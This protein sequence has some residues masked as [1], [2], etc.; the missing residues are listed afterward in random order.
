MATLTHSGELVASASVGL[1]L[2]VARRE[3]VAE[4]VIRLTLV[5]LTGG[6]LPAWMPGAHI[7]LTGPT[8]I[9]GQYSLCGDPD[10]VGVWHVAVLR[11]ATG[12]GG[13]VAIHDRL[14]KGDSILAAGPRNHFRLTDSP[15]Y[16]FIAGGI[17]ITPIIPMITLVERENRPWRLIYT[18]RATATMAFVNELERYGARVELHPSQERG[19]PDLEALI[20]AADVS[21]A[22]FCCGPPAMVDAVSALC[23]SDPGRELRVERFIP[24]IDAEAAARGAAFDVEFIRSERVLHVA[25]GQTIVEAMEL[26]GLEA[27]CSCR[28]GVCG[29]CETRVIA[30]TPDHRDSVLEAPERA[31][32]N[33][34]MICVSRSL[35]PTL[36]LDA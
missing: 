26:A 34:M 36:V 21:A 7:D 2:T 4:D 25:N 1:R 8:G 29:T 32:G 3:V 13:S 33:T 14:S 31:E 9:I 5:S 20:S 35:T 28:E 18:G 24:E 10:D 27:L 11:E 12:S 17:G 15:S 22:V 16:L 30:G 19:R 23:G 6:R